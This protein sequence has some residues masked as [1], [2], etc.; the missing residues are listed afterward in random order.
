MTKHILSLSLLLITFFSAKSQ[1]EIYG[2]FRFGTNY[3]V[4]TEKNDNF[5]SGIGYNIGYYEVLELP[6]K[7]NF[8]VEANYSSYAFTTKFGSNKETERYS[9]IEIPVMVKYRLSPNVAAGIG[10]QFNLASDL[11]TSGPIL[12][13]SSKGPKT[14]FGLRLF[15]ADAPTGDNYINTSLYLGFS[16]F[17]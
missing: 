17:K 6:N 1:S 8:Q 2:G 11:K 5:S 13:I 3:S 16:I 14:I 15:S 7:I 12:D 10:Y 4:L 9:N